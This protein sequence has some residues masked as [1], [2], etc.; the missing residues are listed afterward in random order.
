[1]NR[2]VITLRGGHLLSNVSDL[3]V[4]VMKFLDEDFVR[5]TM[6]PID[7]HRVSRLLFL[8]IICWILLLGAI[9]EMG[10]TLFDQPIPWNGINNMGGNCDILMV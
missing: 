8:C 10:C 2:K 5:Q 7:A 9:Q 6:W 3:I 4:P 1:M